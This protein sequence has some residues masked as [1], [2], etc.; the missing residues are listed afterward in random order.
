MALTR[1]L[2]RKGMGY[3]VGYSPTL[4]KHL[5]Q[6]VTGIAVRYFEISREE[7]TTYTQDPSTLDTLATKC[8]N[9][10]TGSTR[11]V[12]SSV[13]TENTP[14]QAASYQQLMNG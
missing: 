12:C 9:L 2:I 13:L 7:Y 3:S 5:L 6:T 8:K 14:S 11:F 1:H 10:G 4:R